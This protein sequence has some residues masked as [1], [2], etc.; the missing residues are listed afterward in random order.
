MADKLRDLSFVFVLW[1]C[2]EIAHKADSRHKI[3][4]SLFTLDLLIR[5]VI[6][7]SLMSVALTYKAP[8][9]RMPVE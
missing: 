7:L 5:N 6:T 9:G 8:D 2:K 4:N 1:T 3:C